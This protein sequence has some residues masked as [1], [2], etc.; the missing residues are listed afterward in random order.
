MTSAL[1]AKAYASGV[2]KPEYHER[3]VANLENFAQD[4]GIQPHWI[5]TALPKQFSAAEIDYVRRF[6]QHSLD[7]KVSGLCYVGKAQAFAIEQHMA[8]LAGCFVRNFIR[9]RVMTLG[10]VIEDAAATRLPDYSAILIPNFFL[11]SADVGT[12]AKWQLQT[13]HD[14]LLERQFGARQTILYVSDMNLLAKEYGS[15]FQRLIEEHY[16]QVAV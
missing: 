16:L 15:A 4:A 13:I 12:V 8:A 14:V 3:L 10:N 6:R 11:K 9:A 2:L 1:E 7:G 5:W